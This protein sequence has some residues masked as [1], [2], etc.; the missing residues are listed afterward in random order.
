M[1]YFITLS[2]VVIIVNFVIT[3]KNENLEKRIGVLE[4]ER[5]NFLIV[6]R[7]EGLIPEEFVEKV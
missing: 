3:K 7:Q 4:F 2:F 1:W 5:R 6:L